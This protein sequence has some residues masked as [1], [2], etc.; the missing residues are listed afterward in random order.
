[1]NF[2]PR[3]LQQDISLCVIQRN[4][5]PMLK[6]VLS[7]CVFG[8]LVLAAFSLRPGGVTVRQFA[9]AQTDSV[10]TVDSICVEKSIREMTVFL[11]DEPI[12]TYAI[13]LGGNPI[14]HKQY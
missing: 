12:K 1:V 7:V 8:A 3:R 9:F 10:K 11:S 4:I 13:A 5:P 2:P 14:G 6:L